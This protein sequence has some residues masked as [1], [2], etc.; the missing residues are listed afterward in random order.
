MER[1][2]L[3]ISLFIVMFIPESNAQCL[4]GNCHNGKGTYQFAN[5]DKYYGQWKEGKMTGNGKYEFANGDRYNG[6]FVENK[7]DGTG[8]YVWKNKGSYTGQWK[9][10]KR[11]GTGIFKWENSASY[12]GFWNDDQIIDMDVNTVTDCQEKPTFGN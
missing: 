2:V 8:V 12:N 4:K 7:R 6:D 1:I 11:E 3:V 10:G 5:G 9:A